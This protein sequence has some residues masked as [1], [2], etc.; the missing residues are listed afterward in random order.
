[1][2]DGISGRPAGLN[3]ASVRTDGAGKQAAAAVAPAATP[4]AAPQSRVELSALASAAREASSAPVDQARVAQLRAAI[5]DG[6][7][8]VDPEKIASK[9]VELDLGWAAKDGGAE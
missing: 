3:E 8:A 7:Y 2:I 6:S 5:A 9:M 1:M 4:D